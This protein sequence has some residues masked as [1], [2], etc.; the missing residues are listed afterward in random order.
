MSK[1]SFAGDIDGMD[2]ASDM[3]Y[4]IA[5]CDVIREHTEEIEQ[6]VSRSI[7]PTKLVNEILDRINTL[8]GSIEFKAE[9]TRN[10]IDEDI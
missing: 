5:R 6:L 4:I 3:N 7:V 1:V 10:T 2:I 8:T 9:V